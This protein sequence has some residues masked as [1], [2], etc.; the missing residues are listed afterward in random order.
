MRRLDKLIL[1]ELLGPFVFGVMIFTVLI[2]A[3]T[4]LYTFTRFLS[5]GVPLMTV[6]TLA[7]YSLPGI[8]A[9][10][11]PM[12]MLLGTLLAFGRLSGD[13]EIV[14]LRAG[15]ASILRIMVPVCAAGLAV[16]LATYLVT[17]YLVPSMSLRA[18][19]MMDSINQ[20]L[21]QS[22]ERPV[23][24]P[25]RENGKI[26]GYLVA[27][28]FNLAD[29][30]L[31][32]ATV[33]SYDDKL[34]PQY[35]LEVP[36]FRYDDKDNWQAIGATNL[37]SIERDANE[38][39]RRYFV[40]TF[41]D[42]AWPETQDVPRPNMNPKDL[43]ADN[44]KDNDA[45]S[46]QELLKAIE[47]QLADPNAI[48]SKTINLQ[49]GYWNKFALPLAALVFGLVGAPLGIRNHRA[50]TAAGF[51]MSVIIIFGYLMVTNAL[52]IM[53]Q[54]GAIP[55]WLASFGPIAVGLAVAVEL[56]RRKNSQ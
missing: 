30:T 46:S 31:T 54:G 12:A 50:G 19:A 21:D 49:F 42:G 6:L 22:S 38:Q 15:G 11:L 35:F 16:S 41:M 51:W 7:G 37:Y 28:N 55:A 47:K 20:S 45:L 25:I 23:A 52:A 39:P 40:T 43:L 24:Q 33:I 10:T 26:R 29:N 4:F 34:N 53:A 48:K 14:A 36:K 8:I 3:G 17:D 2:M 9:K 18:V 13:S 44:L 5:E 32:H 1:G 27:T 56:I